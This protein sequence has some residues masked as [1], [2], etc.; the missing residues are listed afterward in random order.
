MGYKNTRAL[1][2]TGSG[3]TIMSERLARELKLPLMPL[4][5]GIKRLLTAS[6]TPLHVVASCDVNF[7]F[8]GLVIKYNV[9]V[10]RNLQENLILRSDVL[11]QNKV[12]IDYRMNKCK[13][14]SL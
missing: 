3:S 13:K 10:V 1:V 7:N 8:S 5:S 4:R 6:G 12:I 2:D 14:R 9:M 11:A